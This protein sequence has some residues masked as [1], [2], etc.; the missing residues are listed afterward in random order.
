MPP[1]CPLLGSRLDAANFFACRLGNLSD[2]KAQTLRGRAW[3]VVARS[4]HLFDVTHITA[5]PRT[6]RRPLGDKELFMRGD[7]IN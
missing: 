3:C 4:R 7:E 2:R 5:P 1:F 6:I